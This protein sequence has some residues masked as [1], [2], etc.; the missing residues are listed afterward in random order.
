MTC[1]DDSDREAGF[2]SHRASRRVPRVESATRS[3]PAP[4]HHANPCSSLRQPELHWLRLPEPRWGIPRATKE[5]PADPSRDNKARC[6]AQSRSESLA[7]DFRF[8]LSR[9][10]PA[11]PQKHRTN[12]QE[13]DTHPV[14]TE[15]VTRML[16]AAREPL[17]LLSAC[18]RIRPRVHLGESPVARECARVPAKTASYSRRCCFPRPAPAASIPPQCRAPGPSPASS[19]CYTTT[20]GASSGNFLRAEQQQALQA[21]GGLQLQSPQ[22]INPHRN[23]TQSC[24]NASQKPGL[25]SAEFND[26]RVQPADQPPDAKQSNAVGQKRNP[27]LHGDCIRLRALVSSVLIQQLSRR[28]Q[29]RNAIA[30]LPKG[31]NPVRQHD[32]SLRA[33]NAHEDMRADFPKPISLSPLDRV[34]HGF[35]NPLARLQHSPVARLRIHSHVSWNQRKLYHFE[36]S[37]F[38]RGI[39]SSRECRPILYGYVSQAFDQ[40][41]RVLLL[42]PHLGIG[43]AQHVISTL[44]RHLNVDKYEVHLALITQ[45]DS[46]CPKFPSSVTVHFLHVRRARHGM[47][48]L[49]RLIWRVRPAVNL[50]WDGAS[51]S[52]YTSAS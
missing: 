19:G 7:D 22:K 34:R 6:P 40:R 49:F 11:H 18:R 15:V 45:S 50:H 37:L 38:V 12:L 9:R 1:E 36:T 13:A 35:S 44:A 27:S 21:A 23:S 48:R 51:R 33:R 24:R 47:F 14:H 2:A 29:K 52:S 8:A 41:S 4:R 32:S 25:R 39:T 5:A 28:R 17:Y 16:P 46:T 3:H 20:C 10:G 30:S 42:I 31:V 43:G 26:V